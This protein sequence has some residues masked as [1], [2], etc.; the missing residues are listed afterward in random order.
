ME[1]FCQD[2]MLS[3]AAPHHSYP[4]PESPY[5]ATRHLLI[6]CFANWIEVWATGATVIEFRCATGSQFQSR[7]KYLSVV[8][9]QELVHSHTSMATDY[10]KELDEWTSTDYYDDHVHK[11]QLPYAQVR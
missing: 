11:I 9:V 5:Q 1:F 4:T 7:V 10:S 2:I 3:Y 8:L 6:A